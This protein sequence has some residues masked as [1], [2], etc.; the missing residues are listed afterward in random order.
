MYFSELFVSEQF[1]DLSDGK[2]YTKTARETGV[3]NAIGS[4][5]NTATFFAEDEVERV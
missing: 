4:N 3:I 1:R 5:G 2:I